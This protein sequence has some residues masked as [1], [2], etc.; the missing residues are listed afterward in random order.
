MVDWRYLANVYL[1]CVSCIVRGKNWFLGLFK[2]VT[3]DSRKNAPGKLPQKKK[4]LP[5]KAA[6][7]GKFPLG[8]LPQKEKCP[9]KSCDESCPNRKIAP[10]KVASG[11][12]AL[13]LQPDL[14]EHFQ[15]HSV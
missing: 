14:E 2:N 5:R 10:W 11:K 8:N 4:C 15:K 12:T 3:F 1:S 9:L 13:A 7:E 6:P